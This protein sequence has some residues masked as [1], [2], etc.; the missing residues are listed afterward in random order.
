MSGEEKNKKKEFD[1]PI[2]SY[3]YT[4]YTYVA[5]LSLSSVL[6]IMIYDFICILYILHITY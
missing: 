5:R 1:M 3:T 6:C 4:T 2:I